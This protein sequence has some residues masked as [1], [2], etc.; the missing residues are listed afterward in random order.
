MFIDT[1]ILHKLLIKNIMKLS[2]FAMV[3]INTSSFSQKRYEFDY[4][5]EYEK[6]WYKDSMKTKHCPCREKDSI[7]KKYYLTNSL[8]NSYTAVITEV[9]SSTYKM[10]FKDEKGFYSNVTMM[11]SDFY[12]AE[13]IRIGCES[14]RVYENRFKYKTKNYSFFKLPDTVIH[15]ASLKTYKL[16]SL[17]RPNRIKKRH[18]A[19][20]YLIIEN[21]TEFHLPVFEFSIAYEEWKKESHLPNGI[22]REKY[23]IDHRGQMEYKER[24]LNYKPFSTTIV[25]DGGCDF[26]EKY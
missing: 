14:V 15:G 5:L 24:L 1:P 21:D 16:E 9:D 7:T 10:I 3:L 20:L 11:K 8:K 25:I 4:M 2:L 19:T 6:T 13:S 17:L 26:S 22:F 23:L 12:K 18:I